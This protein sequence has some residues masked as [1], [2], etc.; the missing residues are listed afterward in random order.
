MDISLERDEARI[1]C[2]I[3]VT[4]T[5]KQELGNVGKCLAA[6]YDKV[7]LLASDAKVLNRLKETV[8]EE[9]DAVCRERV[10]VLLPDELAGYLEEQEAEAAA[11]EETVHGYKVK[12]QYKPLGEHEKDARKQAI[13][14]IILGALKRLK[15][16]GK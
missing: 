13:S 1:A 2:E 3:S 15:G 5:E 12:V 4:S 8:S 16:G 6:G 14:Q 7:V 9:L 10:L 11:R